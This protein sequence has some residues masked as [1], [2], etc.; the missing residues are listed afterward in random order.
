MKTKDI[1]KGVAYSKLKHSSSYWG[2]VVTTEKLYSFP[3]YG[4]DTSLYSGKGILVL[5][6]RAP[7]GNGKWGTQEDAVAVAKKM[8]TPSCGS[9]TKLIEEHRLSKRGLAFEI[10][11]PRQFEGTTADVEA[12][13]RAEREYDRKLNQERAATEA[14]LREQ[15]DRIQNDLGFKGHAYFNMSKGTGSMSTDGWKQMMD[16]VEA[17]L[18]SAGPLVQG[19]L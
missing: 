5:A 12:A 15:F 10:W 2:V 8:G 13:R 16:R 19:N 9:I 14:D 7:I 11:Q 18:Q 3:T 4:P 6:S 17:L 1:V